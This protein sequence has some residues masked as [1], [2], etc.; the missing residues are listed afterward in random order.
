M[1]SKKGTGKFFRP[2]TN[3]EEWKQ[4][5][6]EP[7]KQWK[8]GH[9]AKALAYC[10]QD[11]TDFPQAVKRVFKNSGI[12]LFQNAELLMGMPEYR[13]PLPGGRR[14]SQNDIFILAKGNGQLIS[15]AVEGKAGESFGEM[16]A[17]W[18]L[19]DRGGKKKRLSFLRSE[20]QLDENAINHIRYQLLHR[21]VSAVIQAK[22]FKAEN[23]LM[24]VHSF[25]RLRYNEDE[26]FQDY[27]QFLKLFGIKGRQNSLSFAKKIGGIDLY[28]G[29]VKGEK[30][31]LKK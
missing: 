17:D 12:E 7:D 23:A 24:L 30:K 28:F 26:A 13:V 1:S 27:C 20:L 6:A 18:R 4:L 25:S 14:A 9:S 31:Y 8:T 19:K 2:I 22:T 3:P 16:V 10:W 5:L 11:A 15:I 21:T 29:W